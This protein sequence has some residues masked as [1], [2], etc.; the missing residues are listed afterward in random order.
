M[1]HSMAI[2]AYQSEVFELGRCT[3]DK[4]F[5]R[6]H[7]VHLDKSSAALSVANLEIELASLTPEM[8]ERAKRL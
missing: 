8:A 4:S 3:F 6:S 1:N 5:D 7:M 2:C